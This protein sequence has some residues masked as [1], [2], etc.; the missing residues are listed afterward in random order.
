VVSWEE[1]E[2]AQRLVNRTFTP[3]SVE[4][5][6]SRAIELAISNGV[7]LMRAHVAIDTAQELVSLEGVLRARERWSDAIEIEVVALLDESIVEHPSFWPA[8]ARRCGAAPM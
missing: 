1:A 5:R 8:R 3:E 6:A 2:T 4:S 7:G